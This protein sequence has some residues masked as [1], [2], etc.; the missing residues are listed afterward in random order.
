MKYKKINFDDI[1]F[2]NNLLGNEFVYS[3]DASRAKYSHDETED[4]KYFPE[5]VLTPNNTN[6]V[7]KILD[8]CNSNLIP[9][10]ACGARTGLSGGSLPLF[11]GVALSLERF[12]SIIKI[13]ERNLQ[14]T[15]EPGVVNQELRD[16]VEKK[17]LFYQL[18]HLINV[19][20][21][22]WGLLD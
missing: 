6:E 22:T 13:D 15:V 21:I 20:L 11:G 12:N 10:T 5:L 18:F 8:Y 16:A 1:S 2:F 14:V 17:N 4:L 7:S 3:D 19:L 9:I